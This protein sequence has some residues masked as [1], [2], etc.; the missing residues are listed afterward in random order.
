MK[1]V[2]KW[3]NLKAIL[4]YLVILGHIVDFFTNDSIDMRRIFLFIYIFH[5]PCFLFVSGMLSKKNINEHRYYKIFSYLVMFYLTKTIL[6]CSN[7]YFKGNVSFSFFAEI[8]VPWYVFAMFIF[9]LITIFLKEIDR[10]WVM[11]F[12]LLLGCM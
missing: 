10:R 2:A 9:S 11:A 6:W 1:R 5:M 8:G 4:I 12:I 7:V 3:D